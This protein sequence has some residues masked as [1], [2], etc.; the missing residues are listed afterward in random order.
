LGSDPTLTKGIIS[1]PQRIFDDTKFVQSDAEINPGNSGGPLIDRYGRVIGVNT[2]TI[3]LTSPDGSVRG[4][5][6]ISL[7]VASN[8]V[9]DRLATYEAGGP[10]QATYRNLRW[11]YGYS[12]VI[13]RGWYLDAESGE[14]LSG[15]LTLFKA[16]G[17]E[18][19]SDILTL[20][21]DQPYPV[22]NRAFGFLP[23][24]YWSVLLPRFAENWHF[25]QPVSAP[26]A[27]NI[28]GQT[29]AHMEYRYQPEQ[30]DCIFR[31][32][33]LTSISSDFPSK[34][35]GFITTGAV[36]EEV[37]PAYTAEQNSIIYSFRP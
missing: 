4:A 18:R 21:F 22:A 8:E 24:F 20:E 30:E 26:Q 17:G 36:C 33:A 14:T 28:G 9:R 11:G 3:T 19:R 29:F 37:M 5:P 10:M 2:Y 25:F 15:Q 16:Y 6:G 31:E 13:P 35:L 27:V 23:G 7:S 34:P 1:S 32:V 12:M